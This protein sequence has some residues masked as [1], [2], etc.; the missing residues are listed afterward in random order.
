[1]TKMNPEIRDEWAAALESGKYKQ[2]TG[3]LHA[4]ETDEYCCLGVLCEIA[5]AKGI[6]TSE[7]KTTQ[8]GILAEHFGTEAVGISHEFLPLPVQQWTGLDTRDP[9]IEQEE[10]DLDE[11][12]TGFRTDPITDL[13]DNAGLNFRELAALIRAQL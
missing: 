6:I 10:D 13:N 1:M 12:G 7:I 2:G 8:G 9:E 11:D 5:K 3:Y 4:V